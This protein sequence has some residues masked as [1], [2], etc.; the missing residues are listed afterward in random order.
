MIKEL[1]RETGYSN[2]NIGAGL[3][4]G[5]GEKGIAAMTS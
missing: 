3:I 4:Q 5:M 2:D 1:S